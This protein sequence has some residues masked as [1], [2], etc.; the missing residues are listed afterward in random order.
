MS[1][2]TVSQMEAVLL[3]RIEKAKAK[4]DKS[5]QKHKLEIPKFR[6]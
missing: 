1:K 4:L 5:Q 3:D 6:S 2:Q